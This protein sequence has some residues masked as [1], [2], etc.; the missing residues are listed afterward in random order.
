MAALDLLKQ[1]IQVNP[2]NTAASR[3]YG[4]I[5]QKRDSLPVAALSAADKAKYD[6]AYT[7][8][9]NGSYQSAYDLV[10][11]IWKTTRNQGYA[12]LKFLKKKLE[13]TLNI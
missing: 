9:T 5:V 13:V 8:Y 4:Q 12:S 10:L 2:E 6:Q 3:L 7:L 1:A 11:E